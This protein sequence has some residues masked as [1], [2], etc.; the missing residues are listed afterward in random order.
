M[1][2][3]T[4]EEFKKLTGEDPE[5]LFGCNWENE[6]EEYLE[7]NG[8]LCKDCGNTPESGACFFCKMD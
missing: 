2:K 6:I 1:K 7:D 8:F 3:M 4:K 5:D